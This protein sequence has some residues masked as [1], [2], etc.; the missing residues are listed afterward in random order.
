MVSM[1]DERE[2]QEPRAEVP[3]SQA[4][5]IQIG[6]S[7]RKLVIWGQAGRPGAAA[8]RKPLRMLAEIKLPGPVDPKRA[9]ASVRNAVLAFEAVKQTAGAA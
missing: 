8:G 9:R 3:G 2:F 6:V 4:E 7:P 5:D 1:L